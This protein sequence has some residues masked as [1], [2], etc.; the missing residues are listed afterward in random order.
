[1]CSPVPPISRIRTR[2]LDSMAEPLQLDGL[3]PKEVCKIICNSSLW[4]THANRSF[5]ACATA[6]TLVSFG[7]HPV[8]L[9]LVVSR[10]IRFTSPFHPPPPTPPVQHYPTPVRPTS[11]P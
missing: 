5:T 4:R 8:A 10:T 7:R 2:V 1:M 11:R 3:P 6:S 9:S